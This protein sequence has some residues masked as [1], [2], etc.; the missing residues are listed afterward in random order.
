MRFKLI[1]QSLCYVDVK[2]PKNKEKISL[3]NVVRIFLFF[4]WFLVPS[5]KR[6]LRLML[7]VKD[8]I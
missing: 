3:G 6:V 5:V 2:L 1:R 7:L 8:I 4:F